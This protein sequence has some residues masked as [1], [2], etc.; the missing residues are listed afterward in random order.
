MASGGDRQLRVRVWD[1]DDIPGFVALAERAGARVSAR[2]LAAQFDR[3]EESWQQPDRHAF[4][5][6][7][8]ELDGTLVGTALAHDHI[9]VPRGWLVARVHVDPGCRRRGI[10]A[11]LA[12]ALDAELQRFCPAG[13][14]ARVAEDNRDSITWAER[15]GFGLVLREVTCTLDL[16]QVAEAANPSPRPPPAGIQY[17]SLASAAATD[18]WPRLYRLVATLVAD[19]PGLGGTSGP[20]VE[21]VECNFTRWAPAV[22]EAT[23]V[24]ADGDRWIGVTIAGRYGRDGLYVWFTGVDARWRGLGIAKV[25]K[26][27]AVDASRSLGIRNMVSH[28]VTSNE[29]MLALNAALGAK[30]D[31]PVWVLRRPLEGT[32]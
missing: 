12:S 16:S 28:V 13:L 25:L 27:R 15:R 1:V 19:A 8:A 26:L 20:S 14:E 11:A 10:G 31:D 22:P 5:R 23:W 29:A 21:A 9:L 2:D 17:F 18:H 6:L 24:A 7:G 30:V 4:V 3:Q 32:R